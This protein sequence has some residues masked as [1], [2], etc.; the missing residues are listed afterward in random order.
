VTTGHH[1]ADHIATGF[2]GDFGV[3]QFFLHLGHFFLHLLRLLHQAGHA[4]F[5]HGNH[6]KSTWINTAP[7]LKARRLQLSARCSL[8]FDGFNSI[9]SHHR[10]KL[11]NHLL[12]QRVGMDRLL[13]LALTLEPA[14][15][16]RL[17]RGF[18]LGLDQLDGD[19][20]GA[21]QVNWFRASLR[22][23]CWV[24]LNNALWAGSRCNSQ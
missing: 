20:Q 19:F 7:S 12:D 24:A 4:T 13:G 14:T 2:T 9:V 1:H 6:L 5:H 11:L 8:G 16:G 17:G 18:L 15:G 23:R 10:A 3:G 21:L 22:R